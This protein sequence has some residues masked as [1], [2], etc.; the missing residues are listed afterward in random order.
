MPWYLE[1]PRNSES[2]AHFGARAAL[3]PAALPPSQHPRLQWQRCPPVPGRQS[4]ER[5]QLKAYASTSLC[6]RRPELPG[7]RWTWE[8]PLAD[9]RSVPPCRRALLE[10]VQEQA[11]DD[12]RYVKTPYG[13]AA[14]RVD[15]GRPA[16]DDQDAALFGGPSLQPVNYTSAPSGPRCPGPACPAPPPAA[17]LCCD[18]QALCSASC[19]D[20]V[21]D[22]RLLLAVAATHASGVRAAIPPMHGPSCKLLWK[23]PLSRR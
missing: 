9:A 6:G 12:D 18:V 10:S 13:V 23:L 5:P 14:R 20:M 15:Q 4:C 22:S 2:F 7:R 21:L 19:D 11:A 3:L 8:Q 1:G 17:R 16:G